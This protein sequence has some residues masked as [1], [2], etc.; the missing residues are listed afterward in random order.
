MDNEIV[1]T[2]GAHLPTA[3][4]GVSVSATGNAT[5]IGA[6]FGGINFNVDSPEAV[7]VL[8]ELFGGNIQNRSHALEWA[9]L[10]TERFNLFVLENENYQNGMFCMGKRVSLERYTDKEFKDFF[11]P[12]SPKAKDE[13]KKMPCIFARKNISFK[14]AGNPHPAALGRLTDIDCQ[15][16]QIRFCFELFKPFIEQQFINDHIKEFGLRFVTVRNQ[17]D[18][19]HWS[20]RAG[21]LPQIIAGF[22]I[23]IE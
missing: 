22:G 18:E 1:T 10:N 5:A 21:N 20:I 2:G 19:E 17:L 7:A 15:G 11:K 6:L 8:R 12:L 3:R 9:S 14:T 13:L 16:E 23:Q 4:A